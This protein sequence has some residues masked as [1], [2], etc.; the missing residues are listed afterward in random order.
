MSKRDYH[1]LISRYTWTHTA[2]PYF[3]ALCR[4]VVTHGNVEDGEATNDIQ[5]GKFLKERLFSSVRVVPSDPSLYKDMLYHLINTKRPQFFADKN[6]VGCGEDDWNP[7]ELSILG[8][9]GIAVSATVY[10]NGRH[11][12]GEKTCTTYLFKGL[13]F[14]FLEL[15]CKMEWA[16]S[17]VIFHL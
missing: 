15:C 11:G 8:D 2:I 4:H 7:T 5:P 1:I 14:M 6:V 16:G 13:S 3:D 10:D 9:I 17:R 12:I